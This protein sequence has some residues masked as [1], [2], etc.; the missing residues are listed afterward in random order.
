LLSLRGLWRGKGKGKGMVEGVSF[1]GFWGVV[2]LDEVDVDGGG[3]VDYV[4][5]V[6]LMLAVRMQR[7]PVGLRRGLGWI[8]FCLFMMSL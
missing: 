7:V 2:V 4:L 1:R 6:G 3:E 5:V 8:P